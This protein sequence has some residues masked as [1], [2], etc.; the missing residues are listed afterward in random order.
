[1]WRDPNFRARQAAGA[2][3]VLSDLRADPAFQAREAQ[4]L[5]AGRRKA[6]ET[7]ALHAPEVR[8][9]H[10]RTFTARRLSWCPP[11]LR[12]MYRDLMI[13]QH[14]TAAEARRIVL[15]HYDTELTRRQNAANDAG[16]GERAA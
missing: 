16:R 14:H 9:K 1:M 10:G 5:T 2:R 11:H 8:K 4:R 3:Q 12:D 7:G 6:I 13:N 15:E